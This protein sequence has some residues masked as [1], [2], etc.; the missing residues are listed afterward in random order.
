MYLLPS[1]DIARVQAIALQRLTNLFP[2]LQ[3]AEL[4]IAA[5]VLLIDCNQSADV[6]KIAA[7]DLLMHLIY[8]TT[9]CSAASVCLSGVPILSRTQ[10][11][12]IQISEGAEMAKTLQRAATAEVLTLAD[13]QVDKLAAAIAQAIMSVLDTDSEAKMIP[14]EPSTPPTPPAATTE[15]IAPIRIPRGAFTPAKSNWMQSATRYLKA[16]D[17]GGDGSQI[18]AAIV[19]KTPLGDAHLNKALSYLPKAER[20]VAREKFYQGFVKV[21]EKR[22]KA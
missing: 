7:D 17:P 22:E 10:L 16:V 11:R 6:E 13:G 2:I 5:D 9:G 18:L 12:L 1:S 19:A 20:E 14:V 3:A 21:A 15:T 8:L 4:T